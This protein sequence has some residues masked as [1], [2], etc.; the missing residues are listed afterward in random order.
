[1]SNIIINSANRIKEWPRIEKYQN[2][3]L[4]YSP[5]SNFPEFLEKTNGRPKLMRCW[6]TL[7]EVW[8]YRTDQY[9]FDYQI[10]V[11]RYK[12]DP[13]HHLYDWDTTTPTGISIKE[14]LLTHSEHCDE[15]MLNIRRYEGETADG[16]VSLD[17]YEEVVERVIE[18]YKNLCPNIRYIESCNESDYECF[19]GIDPAHYYELYRR[20][21]RAVNRINN[22]NHYDIP[23]GVG[24]TAT[25]AVMDKPQIWRSFLQNLAADKD[26]GRLIDFYSVHDYNEYPERISAFYKMHNVWIKE[27]GL[28]E[29]TIYV[30][31]YGFTDTTGVWT[32]S[33]KNAAGVLHAMM[34]Y[35]P[36][37]NMHFMPWCTFHNPI[38]QMSFTQFLKLDDDSYVPTPNGNA[39][40]M[41]HMLKTY[42]LEMNGENCSNITATG[43][44]SGI[45]IL[46]TNAT[47]KAI[48]VNLSLVGLACD[49]V[50]LTQYLCDTLHN[51]RLTGPQ[52]N[53]LLLTN[54]WNTNVQ[55]ESIEISASLDMYGFSLWVIK[56]LSLTNS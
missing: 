13:K 4:R 55:K 17:K 11:N 40:K 43:D 8:D 25:N 20:I 26:P 5:T 42:Q 36:I 49:K 21:Y 1:M 32:D 45:A 52:C 27:L 31:E 46:V 29:L 16:T 53:E 12:D 22:R 47:D 30:D 54:R 50:E 15:I 37:S 18:Y 33:L 44:D 23:L 2:S 28:P 10:G 24:G 56:P 38:N 14:H 9:F 6:V 41:L 34:M 19:G 3:T 48:P 7:D 35:A 39:M 51:N